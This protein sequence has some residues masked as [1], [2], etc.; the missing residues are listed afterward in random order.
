MKP[1]LKWVGGK[2]QIFDTLFERFPSKI[3]NYY[4]PFVE[5]V[6]YSSNSLIV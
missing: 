3:S 6:L 5:G 1:V 2:T 4:E